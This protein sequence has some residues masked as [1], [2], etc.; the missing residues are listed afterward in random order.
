[1]GAIELLNGAGLR[2]T[3]QR[4]EVLKLLEAKPMRAEEIFDETDGIS[5]STVYRTLDTLSTCGLAVK[6][7]IPQS[8]GIYYELVGNEHRHYAICL[9]CHKLKYID[10]C[11]IQETEVSDFIVT[12]HKIELYGYCG[13]CGGLKRNT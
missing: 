7:T 4:I 13:E 9:S 10:E 8:D 2:C 12:G 6:T 11:P 1:M 3:K 5:L